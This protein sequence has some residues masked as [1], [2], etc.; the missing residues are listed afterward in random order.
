MESD[1]HAPTPGQAAEALA[2]TERARESMLGV[3]APR[4]MIPAI[5]VLVGALCAANA[6]P[7]LPGVIAMLALCLALG[8]TLGAAIKAT[9]VKHRQTKADQRWIF[10]RA[11][12][13]A[14]TTALYFVAGLLLE[15]VAGLPWMWLPL[16][17]LCAVTYYLRAN[18]VLRRYTPGD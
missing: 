10:G 5:A 1:G 9:G 17:F 4:W 3:R 13:V 11:A 2:A 15:H 7:S 8:A 14:L 6:L 16:G 12:L 18:A